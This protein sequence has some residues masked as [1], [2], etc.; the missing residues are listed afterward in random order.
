VRN[1]MVGRLEPVYHAAI[2]VIP[3]VLL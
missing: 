2:V 3:M 1:L